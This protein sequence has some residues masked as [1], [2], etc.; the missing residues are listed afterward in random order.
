MHSLSQI[1]MPALPSSPQNDCAA[2]GSDV[3]HTHTQQIKIFPNRFLAS[4][5]Q[6]LSLRSWPQLPLLHGP[7][8]RILP[9]VTTWQQGWLPPPQRWHTRLAHTSSHSHAQHPQDVLQGDCTMSPL[10]PI[11]GAIRPMPVLVCQHV[12]LPAGRLGGRM[13]SCICLLWAFL[14]VNHHHNI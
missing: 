3:Q 1:F 2:D 7:S 11:P 8:G 13:G 9:I 4:S 10:L 12:Q 5:R 6:S 14:G